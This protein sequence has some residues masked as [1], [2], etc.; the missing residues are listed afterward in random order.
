M[1]ANVLMTSAQLR[2]ENRRFRNSRGV[3]RNNAADGFRPAFRDDATG[4]VEL[5][6]FADGRPAPMH[7]LE[8]A[9]DEWVE[10]RGAGGRVIALIASITSGF[11]KRGRFYTRSEAASATRGTQRA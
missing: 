8:G 9:P 2:R 6:R 10:S 11:V 7:L 3:S 5:C 4:R 1:H